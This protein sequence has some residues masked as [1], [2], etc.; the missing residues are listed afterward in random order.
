M[1]YGQSGSILK[2]EEIVVSRLWMKLPQGSLSS[3]VRTLTES[4]AE[5]WL[6]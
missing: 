3:T 2:S 5:N 4:L 6:P 1:S